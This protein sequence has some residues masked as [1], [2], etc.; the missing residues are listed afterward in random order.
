LKSI[1]PK[2][3]SLF[4]CLLAFLIIPQ[5]LN[6]QGTSSVFTMD[7]T[8]SALSFATGSAKEFRWD[9]FFREGSFSIGGHYGA[10]STALSPGETGFLMLDN[11][12]FYPVAQ[13]YLDKGELV[14][15]QSFVDIAKEAFARTISQ[16]DSNYRIAAI[17]VDPGHGGKEPGAVGNMTVNG[18]TEKLYEKDIDLKAAKMLRDMLVKAYPDKRILMTRESDI[19]CSLEE[20]TAIANSVPIRKNEA[21]IYISIHA[22]A[23]RDI[24]ARG[25]EVWHINPEFQRKLLDDSHFPDS[26]ELRQIMNILT[27]EAFITESIRIAQ[28]ILDALKTA[29]GRT[30]PS[31]GLK[32]ENFFVVRRSNMPAVLVELGFVTNREDVLLMT[33]DATLLKLIEAVYKGVTDFVSDFERSGGFV[34]QR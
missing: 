7:E 25:F 11:R 13:P 23:S 1:H 34:A 2:T 5:N 6:A 31:R 17:I 22:N 8:L 12:D 9:P 19:T 18:K 10:F 32:A 20:R 33:N 14:F 15:P 27:Q 3:F 30:M 21:I 29:M 26:P 24:K 16:D 4:F 28:S